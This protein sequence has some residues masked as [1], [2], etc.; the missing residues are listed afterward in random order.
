MLTLQEMKNIRVKK[1]VS[2]EEIAKL[3]GVSISSVQKL[4]G[5]DNANP[6]RTTLE[7]LNK[8]FDA[9]DA[10]LYASYNTS[11]TEFKEDVA[12]DITPQYNLYGH[13]KM[14]SGGNEP[15][16]A[17]SGYTYEDYLDLDL[18]EGKRVE[19]IDGIIYDMAS[20]TETHQA[21]IGYIFNHLTNEF[22]KREMYDILCAYRYQAGFFRWT[23]YSCTARYSGEMFKGF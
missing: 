9:I 6:R 3:S 4:F 1:G 13:G 10:Y 17:N 11:D 21:I 22:M 18:P 20:P 2:Y 16:V 8:A 14:V 15:I 23:N 12:S 19:V 5:S 7:K